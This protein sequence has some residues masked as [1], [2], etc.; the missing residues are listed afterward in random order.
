MLVCESFGGATLTLTVP[1]TVTL[2]LACESFG[3]DA[4]RVEVVVVERRARVAAALREHHPHLRLA[5]DPRGGEHRRVTAAR[6]VPAR[7]IIVLL[8]LGLGLALV[9]V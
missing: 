9:L 3:G 5:L 7:P 4:L 1:L 2:L 6:T 8:V